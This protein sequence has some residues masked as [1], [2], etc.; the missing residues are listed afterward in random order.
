[1]LKKNVNVKAVFSAMVM[2][3]MSSLIFAFADTPWTGVAS[4]ITEQLRG[5]YDAVSGMVLVIGAAVAIYLLVR[6]LIANA[7]G[8]PRESATFRKA[9]IS[10]LIVIA[11]IYAIPKLLGVAKDLGQSL[12]GNAAIG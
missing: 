6:M 8:D 2:A 5:F 4:T 11:V 7:S 1:M 12:N 10:V 9:L 3:W